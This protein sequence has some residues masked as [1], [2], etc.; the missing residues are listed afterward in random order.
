MPSDNRSATAHMNACSLCLPSAT[1][2][3]DS[4]SVDGNSRHGGVRNRPGLETRLC[5]QSQ[6]VDQDSDDVTSLLCG[7]LLTWLTPQLQPSKIIFVPLKT[8]STKSQC[9][10]ILTSNVETG[11]NELRLPVTAGDMKALLRGLGGQRAT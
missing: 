2:G 8:L 5:C 7:P 10:T 4:D 3:P 9:V 11:A 1:L 6:G